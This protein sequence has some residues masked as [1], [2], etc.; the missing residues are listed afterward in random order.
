PHQGGPLGEGSIE[1]GLLRCPWHGWDY[2]PITGRAPGFDDGVET[3]PMEI[4][5][6]GV[7]VGLSPEQ[8]HIGT[9]GDLMMETLTN[10]SVRQIFGMVG[11]SNLGLA[12]APRIQEQ[13]GR[14]S[15]YG[16]RHEGPRPPFTT[17][18]T[19]SW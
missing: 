17:A 14:L 13:A 2:D 16:I 18:V 4:R 8:T 3:F 9:A 7:H 19:P 11:H 15:Y 5:D 1:H 10:W 12:D 6:D